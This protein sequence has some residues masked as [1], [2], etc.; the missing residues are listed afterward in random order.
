MFAL[1]DRSSIRVNF[2]INSD[3]IKKFVHRCE[4]NIISRTDQEHWKESDSSISEEIG[5]PSKTEHM[6]S[7]SSN[8]E[9]VETS[10]LNAINSVILRF[11]KLGIEH[12]VAESVVLVSEEVLKDVASSSAE[13]LF[14]I[15]MVSLDFVCI[16]KMI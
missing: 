6:D 5:K 14:L 7:G 10:F 2:A 8:V 12:K 11:S 16:N 4:I 9:F 3:F 13:I 1:S 15:S